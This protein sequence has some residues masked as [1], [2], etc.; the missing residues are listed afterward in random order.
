MNKLKIKSSQNFYVLVS[1]I[2]F[3]LPIFIFG[4]KDNEVYQVGSFSNEFI[5]KK[6]YNPFIFFID[7]LGPGINF[8]LGNYPFYHPV[9]ILLGSDLRFFFLFSG[10]F[11]LLIQVIY[12]NKILKFFHIPKKNTFFSF[13]ILFSISNFN[14]FWSDDWISVFYTYTFYFP[15]IYYLLKLVNLQSFENFVKFS[16]VSGF[17]FI[18]S[19]PGVFYNIVLFAFVFIILN[20]FKKIIKNKYFYLSLILLFSISAHNIYF[21]LN[22]TIKFD[23][24]PRAVQ[25]SYSIKYYLAS[26]GL[27]LNFSW[28]SIT[29]YPFVGLFFIIGLLASVKI[30]KEKSSKK[31]YYI[32]YIFLFFTL[33]SLIEYVKFIPIISGIWQARDIVNISSFILFFI[34]LKDIKNSSFKRKILFINFL[35]ILIFYLFCFY[36]FIPFDGKNKNILVNNKINSNIEKIFSSV[37]KGDIFENR[38]YLGPEIDKEIKKRKFNNLGIFSSTDFTKLNLSPFQGDFKNISLDQVQKS[39]FKMR[40]WLKSNYNEINNKVFLSIFR[41]KYLLLTNEDYKKLNNKNDFKIL[42]DEKIKDKNI[43]FLE[44]LDYKKHVIISKKDLNNVK[45]KKQELIDCI[46]KHKTLFD[47]TDKIILKKLNR[48]SYEYLG[49]LNDEYYLITNFLY[50]KY[51]QSK[52]GK[53]YDLDK[54]LVILDFNEKTKLEFINKPRYYLLLL[55]IIS[56]IITTV[57]LI[58]KKI[59]IK[60]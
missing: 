33:W 31:F 57:Y 52:D 51:W 56:I 44:R 26:L 47:F 60:K 25:Q 13:L 21:L 8:P 54:K 14:N 35:M 38:L 30:F 58:M 17:S 48:A 4:I 20:N 7:I 49:S 12:F 43:L 15:I 37:V 42:F 45:C 19:H 41:I 55:S 16:F 9:S 23:D 2:L 24:V 11:N 53:I 32:N 29:R 40:G 36:K 6:F 34:F 10:I 39:Q 27:P 22:E 59:V 46:E 50:D 18:N 5:N 3:V 28:M 1:I